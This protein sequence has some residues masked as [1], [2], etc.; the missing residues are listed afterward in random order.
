MS[1]R[2]RFFIDIAL[3]IGLLV[4]NDP[5]RTGLAIHE[6][7]SIALIVPVLVHLV[8]NWEWTVHVTKRFFERLLSVS[9]LNLVVDVAL[10]VATVAVM[11]SGLAVSSV[12][13]GFL[14]VGNA[15]NALWVAVHA[16]SASATIVL[17]LTHFALHGGWFVA[18]VSAML[19]GR[20]GSGRAAAFGART[21]ENTFAV[22]GVTAVLAA[23]M[24]VT[25]GGTGA[26]L[27][28]GLDST[29]GSMAVA[30]ASTG[31]RTCPRTGCTASSCH[32]ETGQ[33]PYAQ[34][35]SNS[36]ASNGSAP[37]GSGGSNSASGA[38]LTCPA[39]GCA[40]SSCHA[41]SGE[42]PYDD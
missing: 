24:F 34:G 35:T 41:E 22:L 38:M 33:S 26:M 40:A 23:A 28:L 27:G 11:V 16:T 6:W 9:R 39:T 4:A 17:L 7:L 29:T 14:G 2:S 8:I 15:A 37:S 36:S 42:S 30:S 20:A 1:R 19:D 3:L 31:T 10:F 32:A 13:T 12:V 25:V 18:T 5:A 21:L